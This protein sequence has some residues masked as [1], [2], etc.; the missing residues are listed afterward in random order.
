MDSNGLVSWDETESW[1]IAGPFTNP[2][3]AAAIIEARCSRAAGAA[4]PGSLRGARE[5][6]AAL[7]DAVGKRPRNTSSVSSQPMQ[8]SVTLWP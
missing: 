8:G 6:V 1:A 3:P 4:R 2:V 7:G 5:A